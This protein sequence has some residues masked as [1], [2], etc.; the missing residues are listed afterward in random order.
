MSEP[1]PTPEAVVETQSYTNPVY[2]GYFAD[3]FVWKYQGVYYAIGTGPAEAQ[4]QVEEIG[5]RRV[6]PLLR[7]DDLVNWHFAGNALLR[8]D[9]A[10]GDNFWAPEVAYCDGTFYLYYSV[11][12]EDKNHQLRVA[13][14]NEPL[15]P[16]QDVGEPLLNPASCP[17]AIDPHPFCDDD[18][19]WYL[20]YARDFLDSDGGVRAGTALMVAR[21]E[22]MTKLAGEGN[23]VLRARCDWQRFLA[24]RP[25]YGG[26][27]DWHT[28]EGPCVRKYAGHYY[29]FYSGG[30]WETENYGV[31]YGVASSVMGPYSDAGNEAGPRVLRSVPDYVLGPGHNSIVSGSN[32]QTDFIVYH[33]WDT[34]MQARRMCIDKLT[35]TPEGPRCNGPTWT[36]QTI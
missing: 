15:G 33:A 31:D 7:S 4:G 29:C 30:R 8:P 24:N 26:M 21:L 22:G 2:Q 9:P 16:Y 36:P 35:W 11:G 23:V 20:F 25:M 3:P 6:F 12:H 19:Q 18:G 13:T 14:S 27:Y 32:T 10:L 17:F 34:G 28:L 5:K 1:E